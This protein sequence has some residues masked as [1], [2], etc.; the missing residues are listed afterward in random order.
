MEVIN[1]LKSSAFDKPIKVGDSAY[2]LRNRELDN[3][4]KYDKAK[5]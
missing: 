2:G 4:S 3:R 1:E 5:R